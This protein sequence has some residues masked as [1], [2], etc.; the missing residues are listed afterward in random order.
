MIQV[1]PV[2][3][4]RNKTFVYKFPTK[5]LQVQTVADDKEL[6]LFFQKQ[7][8]I[9]GSHKS[10]N[11]SVNS[12]KNLLFSDE[13]QLHESINPHNSKNCS[14]PF[15]VNSQEVV[16]APYSIFQKFYSNCHYPIWWASA[17]FEWN[18]PRNGM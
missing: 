11:L 9:R 14:G 7:N 4:L 3:N 12:S 18:L 2:S 17:K 1:L 13:N 10:K 8:L 5:F 16:R 6:Q 15:R